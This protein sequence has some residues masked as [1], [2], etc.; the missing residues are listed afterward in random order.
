M[1]RA[2]QS[3]EQVATSLVMIKT[4]LGVFLSCAGRSIRASSQG[5]LQYR[6]CDGACKPRHLLVF[7]GVG[8]HMDGLMNKA[9]Q[10]TERGYLRR[11]VAG[12]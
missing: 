7:I 11:P 5:F 10:L 1:R 2:I 4:C 6:E 12:G 9:I 8:T 3:C